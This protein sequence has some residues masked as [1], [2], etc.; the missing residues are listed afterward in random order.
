MRSVDRQFEAAAPALTPSGII[1]AIL[2]VVARVE[3]T[4]DGIPMLQVVPETNVRGDLV[5]WMSHLGGS[6]EQA[7]PMLERFAATG[8]PAVSFDAVGHGKRGSGD[9]WAFAA[10][11]L[12]QFRR[13]M[14]PILG[15]TTLDAM[16]VLTWAQEHVGRAGAVLVGGV[17]MGG[18]AAVALAGIDDRVRRVATIGSTPDWSRPGMRDLRDSG[19]AVDQGQADAYAQWFADQLDP[20]RHLERYRRGIA[21]TFELGDADHHIPSD[22]ARAFVD[23]LS[24]LDPA[25][26][27]HLRVQ[28]YPGL[29]HLAV[30]TDDTALT[31][32][33]DWL[34]VR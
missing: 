15:Q 12:G 5:L 26:A 31:Q 14:W 3:R 25:A 18:D 29:D 21:I 13:R 8:H 11:V 10:Q 20:I 6:A 27:A 34:L 4:E 24:R 7:L 17:S 2:V 23:E 1:G 16:R 33:A 28:T 19:Q 30:T 9:P 22:N 32:A